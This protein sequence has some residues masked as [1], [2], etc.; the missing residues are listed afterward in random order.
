MAGEA[1][2]GARQGGGGT[3]GLGGLL[4]LGLDEG[5]GPDWWSAPPWNKKKDRPSVLDV[6]RL[7]RRHRPEIQRLLSNWLRDEEKAA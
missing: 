7:L 5:G 3:M 2:G 6:E 1:S 4:E